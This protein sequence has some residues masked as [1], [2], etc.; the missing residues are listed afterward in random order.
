MFAISIETRKGEGRRYGTEREESRR[1]REV[2]GVGGKREESG[3]KGREGR[4]GKERERERMGGERRRG[5]R[6]LSVLF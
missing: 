3:R 5:N 4:K 1:D 6:V 2:E